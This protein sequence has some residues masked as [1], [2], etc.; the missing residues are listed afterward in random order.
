MIKTTPWED[1]DLETNHMV[2]NHEDSVLKAL[3]DLLIQKGQSDV[4]IKVCDRS[5]ICY[6]PHC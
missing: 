1:S 3:R 2:L 4:I 6:I 5:V